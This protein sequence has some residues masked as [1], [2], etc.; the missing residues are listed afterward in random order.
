MNYTPEGGNVRFGSLADIRSAKRH[1]RSTPKSGHLQRTSP[2]PLCA[3]SGHSCL[4]SSPVQSS[5]TNKSEFDLNSS[6][7]GEEQMEN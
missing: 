6:S 3:N 1:V 2:C 5:N 4:L 7:L